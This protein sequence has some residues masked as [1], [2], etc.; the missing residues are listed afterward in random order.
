MLIW[1][2]EHA[3]IG[4]RQGMHEIAGYIV[5]V[6][7]HTEGRNI[8]TQPR[9]VYNLFET[10][11]DNAKSLYSS[12]EDGSTSPITRRC[13]RIQES[14]LSVLDSQLYNRLIQLKLEP[15]MWGIR[16]TRVLFSREFEFD[17]ILTMW[18]LLFAAD[19]KLGLIDYICCALLM[20][21]RGSGWCAN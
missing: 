8:S 4:Y 21:V 20:R 19:P 15:Q 16:W 6:E 9:C 2:K 10:L 3:D 18:D 7:L 12:A 13:I 14:L 5:W 11:M 17:D 1:S